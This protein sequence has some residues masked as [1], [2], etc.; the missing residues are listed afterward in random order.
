MDEIIVIGLK[1]AI[2]ILEKKMGKSIK[3]WQWGLIN[4]IEFIHPIGKK[5][6]FNYFFN[7][8]PFSAPGGYEQ[9]NNLKSM[10][11]S[12]EQNIYTGP[13]TR[14]V[15]DLKNPGLSYGVLPIGKLWPY[16]Q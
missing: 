1:K 9:I 7:L 15:I 2:E 13:S 5:R 11:C 6:P 12:Y 10:A 8:G 14:R 16:S 3:K 4:S